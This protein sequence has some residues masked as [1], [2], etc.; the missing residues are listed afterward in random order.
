MPCK[1]KYSNGHAQHLDT[2]SVNRLPRD[3][4]IPTE[5]RGTR[6]DLVTTEDKASGLSTRF[7]FHVSALFE[8]RFI[9]QPHRPQR[10][11]HV[12]HAVRGRTQRL[13]HPRLDENAPKSL[14]PCSKCGGN[15]AL[16]T[17][18]SSKFGNLLVLQESKT[19]VRERFRCWFHCDD[20]ISK[21]MHSGR[22]IFSGGTIPRV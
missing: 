19:Q 14:F 8:N 16:E 20:N 18:L 22:D 21:S 13:H 17:K 11:A 9:V 1:Y 12:M 2:E 6:G 15:L 3:N 7:L 5:W 4:H 10:P